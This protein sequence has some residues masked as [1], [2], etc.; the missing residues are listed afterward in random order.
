MQL[1][2][3]VVMLSALGAMSLMMT[4]CDGDTATA[5]LCTDDTS[6]TGNENLPPDGQ[7]LCQH[8]Y[9]ERGLSLEREDLRRGGGCVAERVPVRDDAAVQPGP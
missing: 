1:R 6:C 2:K 5:G 4:G 3:M 7:G 9:D 8:V